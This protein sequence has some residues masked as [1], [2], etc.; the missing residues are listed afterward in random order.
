VSATEAARRFSAVLDS[1]EGRGETFVVVRRGRA[2]ARIGPARAANGKAVKELLR[3][4]P[5]DPEWVTDLH[6]LRSVLAVEERRWGD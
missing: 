3:S 2:V 1:V 6:E 5:P 4:S